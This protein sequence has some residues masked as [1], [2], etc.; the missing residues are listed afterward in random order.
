[1]VVLAIITLIA[2]FTIRGLMV[3][4]GRARARGTEAVIAKLDSALGQRLAAF[5]AHR[6]SIVPQPVDVQMAGGPVYAQRARVIAIARAMRQEF[7]EAFIFVPSRTS[8]RIDNDGDSR[9]GIDDDGDGQIDEADEVSAHTDEPDEIIAGNWNPVF[10]GSQRQYA[11]DLPAA[12]QSY[13][14]YMEVAFAQNPSF[15]SAHRPATARAECL[16]MILTGAGGQ[17][18]GTS[19]AEF[20]PDEVAD[21]DGD[22]LMEVVDKWGNP[23]QFFLW[24]SYYT[25]PKQRPGAEIDS[26]DPHQ[27]LLDPPWWGSSARATFESLFRT[28][29]H[30]SDLGTGRPVPKG[31]RTHPLIVSAGPDAGF[32]LFGVRP[33]N[34]PDSSGPDGLFGTLDDT[35]PIGMSLSVGPDGLLGT[36]DDRA[37]IISA[38]ARIEDG[39]VRDN[40][41]RDN[42]NDGQ[43]DEADEVP[44]YG[45]D[46]DNIDNH[47]LRAR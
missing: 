18:I 46:R 19:G 30:F 35:V 43:V 14:K 20:A 41:G 16:Y 11:K 8:D 25:S 3:L 7:P 33:R 31:F 26:D 38:A 28:L 10:F 44:G 24:P 17:G 21:T 36:S 47:G 39:V 32:G 22:G 29:T 2:A 27:L 6:Q 40:D 5:K 42:D 9:N 45:M 37:P 15:V 12:A 1:L 4:P 23:I 34:G 13:L